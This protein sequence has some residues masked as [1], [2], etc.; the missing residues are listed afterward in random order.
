MRVRFHVLASGSSGNAGVLEAGGFGV[1]VDF[2]LPPRLLAPRMSRCRISWDRIDA[3]LLTHGHTDHWNATTLSHLAK[4]RLPIYC[5]EDHRSFFNQETRAFKKLT[6]DGLFRPFVPGQPLQLGP[7]LRCLPILLQHDCSMTC[8]FRFDGPE[9]AVG[10]A[11]DLGSWKPEL[12]QQFA[13]VD[14]LA[15]EFNHDVEMQLVSGRHPML[16]RRV[17]GDAGHLSNEQGA[18]LLAEVV[19]RSQPGR[20]RH[21]VQLHLSQ[22][23]NRPELAESVA[24]KTRESLG[25]ELSIHTTEQGRAG[26]TITLGPATSDFSCP[27]FIQPMLPFPA[28]SP[29][30]T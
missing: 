19:R 24:R 7:D 8:G 28:L 6:A 15:I 17:L 9:W 22:E 4:L 26:P 18:A 27:Q 23:C 10:Y 14:L 21:L 25:I 11:A 20:L 5:H 13:D 29:E 30:L 2:G 1:L 16:I 12:A 3:V